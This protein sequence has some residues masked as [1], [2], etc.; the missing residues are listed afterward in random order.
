MNCR[1]IFC[2]IFFLTFL[3]FQFD[4]LGQNYGCDS[5][6]KFY[7]KASIGYALGVNGDYIYYGDNIKNMST[8][9]KRGKGI[10]YYAA[11]GYQYNKNIGFGLGL[12]YFSGFQQ[13]MYYDSQDWETES[14]TIF[15]MVPS[16]TYSCALGRLRPYIRAGMNIGFPEI[17]IS[18]AYA[19][20]QTIIKFRLHGGASI[21][22]QSA[23]GITFPI[24]KEIRLFAEASFNANSFSPGKQSIIYYTVHGTDTLPYLPV[25]SKEAVFAR[26]TNNANQGQVQSSPLTFPQDRY[27]LG[28]M[29]MNFGIIINLNHLLTMED[30]QKEKPYSYARI[31]TGYG[32]ATDGDYYENEHIDQKGRQHFETLTYSGGNGFNAGLG[33]GHMFNSNIGFDIGFNFVTT[34]KFNYFYSNYAETINQSLYGNMFQFIPA[35]VFATRVKNFQ[36]YAR[37]G[38]VLGIGTVDV[39]Y[40]YHDSVETNVDTWKYYGGLSIGYNTVLGVAYLIN[41]NLDL[42]AEA[43]FFTIYDIPTNGVLL[44]HVYNGK[45]IM[46][47]LST[48][49]KNIIIKSSYNNSDNNDPNKPSIRSPEKYSFNNVVA[50][51]GVRVRF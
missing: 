10:Y 40:Y 41:R 32:F 14:G 1:A 3:I 43:S 16:I 49:E 51:V 28:S 19:Y 2:S 23:V 34:T 17:H 26:K 5:F 47:Q 48:Q 31:N 18:E 7:A 42:F 22:L 20:D 12:E 27:G 36:L 6:S 38:L 21:G 35:I 39:G 9:S 8:V 29:S 50:N 15:Q 45:D 11:L 24:T 30:V 4:A 13:N 37:L 44:D 33:F 25:A 46:D